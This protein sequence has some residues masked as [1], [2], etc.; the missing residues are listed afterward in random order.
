MRRPLHPAPFQVATR[1]TSREINSRIVLDLVRAHQPVSRA[2][3]ARKMGVRRGAITLIVNDLLKRK[4]VFEGQ[5]ARPCAD[6][7]PPS[8]TLTLAW[9]LIAGPVRSALSE[10]ALTAAAAQTEIRPVAANEYPRLRG[11]AALVA[12]PAFA[13]SVVA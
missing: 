13:A 8:S 5:P 4:A 12:A 1:G 11:A 10:R 9:D 2:D 3:L 6:G 7:N